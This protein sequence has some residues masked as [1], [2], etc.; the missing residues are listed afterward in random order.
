MTPPLA[1]ISRKELGAEVGRLT[2]EREAIISAVDFLMAGIWAL[3]W[4]SGA[5]PRWWLSRPDYPHRLE[6]RVR[7]SSGSGP[8]LALDQ[9]PPAAVAA[10]VVVVPNT[11]TYTT[12][13]IATT[14][15]PRQLM[16]EPWSGVD[17]AHR[18]RSPFSP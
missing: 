6:R 3:T 13:A 18:G 14:A 8:G 10:Q 1:G 5:R 7:A 16:R 17:G 15:R 4:S 2:D 9:Q 11:M 12:K